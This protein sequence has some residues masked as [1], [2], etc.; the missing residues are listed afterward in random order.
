MS[1]LE[2]PYSVRDR[3]IFIPGM[4]GYG[5]STLMHCMAYQDIKNGAGVC[6]IDPKG[7]LVTVT[8]IGHRDGFY[9]E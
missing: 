2:L 7:D 3:H 5:K 9:D 8:K 4:T 1:Q 6:V